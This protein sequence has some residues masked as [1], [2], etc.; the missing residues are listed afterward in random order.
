[1]DQDNLQL[2]NDELGESLYSSGDIDPKRKRN[3]VW[4]IVLWVVI[5]ALAIAVCVRAF[6]ISQVAVSGVSMTAGYYDQEQSDHYNPKLT[7]HSGDKVTVNKLAKPKRGDVVVFYKNPVKSKFLGLFASGASIEQGGEYYKLIK[8][9]VALGGDKIWLESVADGKYRLVIQVADAPDGEYLH[10]DYYTKNNQK[11]SPECFILE[12][13]NLGCL[14][15]HTKDNPLVIEQGYF[16]AMGDN[17]V[18]SADSRGEL[19]QVPLTQLFG[20]VI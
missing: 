7:Y 14:E 18:K 9:V 3:R 2:N 1:M 6:V 4:D 11:L 10:E 17:R 15:A 5:V 20:V 12:M 8:R 16:F 13:G 19:G